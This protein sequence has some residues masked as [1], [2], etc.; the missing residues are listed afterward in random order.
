M[1]FVVR[2]LV[3]GVGRRGVGHLSEKCHFAADQYGI[4]EWRISEDLLS[5]VPLVTW[6]GDTASIPVVVP[7]LDLEPIG[8]ELSGAR[9]L[10]VDTKQ[11]R[12]APAIY[13]MAYSG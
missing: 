11:P 2:S 4:L 1:R 6:D 8:I 5:C 12:A 13:A 3:A 10:W 9:L 7:P